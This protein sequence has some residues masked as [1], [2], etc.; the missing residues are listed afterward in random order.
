MDTL[1]LEPTPVPE[2]IVETPTVKKKG[3]LHGR[4][5]IVNSSDDEEVE[6]SP[7]DVN[8]DDLDI[9]TNVFEVIR[10]T[11]RKKIVVDEFN[12]KKSNIKQMVYEQAKESEDKYADLGGAL[13]LIRV[14]AR[15]IRL[16]R[17]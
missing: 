3:K 15:R 4:A 2:T 1:V 12:K 8:K 5:P 14:V 11:S 13:L 16:S 6:A 10:K 17:K 9:S 7:I